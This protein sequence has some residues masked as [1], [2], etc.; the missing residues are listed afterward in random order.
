MDIEQTGVKLIVDASG[1]AARVHA[2]KAVSAEKEQQRKIRG[3]SLWKV[4]GG[5]ENEENERAGGMMQKT[6]MGG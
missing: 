1:M 2:E 3:R 5:V 6:N 4:L